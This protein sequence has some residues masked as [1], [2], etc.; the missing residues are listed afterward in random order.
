[1]TASQIMVAGF[2]IAILI[3]GIVLCLPVCN[4]DG[5]WLNFLD[6]LFTACS[7]VCVTG[8]VTVVPA[9]QFSLVG[10]IVLLLLIQL[11]GLGIIACTMG[12]FLILRRQITVR[13]RVML[14]E[15]Y[16]MNTMSGLV[17][18]LIYVLKGTFFVEGVGALLYAIQFVPQFGLVRGVWY[19]I[20]HAVSAFCNA[21]IDLLGENSLQMYQTNPLINFTTIGL[22]ILSGLGFVVWR[23]LLLAAHRIR[24]KECSAGRA[25]QRMKVHTKLAVI[26][27][28]GL[29]VIGTVGIFAMEYSNPDTLGPLSTG[30]KWM[31]ALFQ[32]VTTRTAGFF[33][34]PQ[35]SLREESKL[36]SCILMFIG[37]SPGGTAGGVKTTTVAL[38]L[39]TCWSVLKGHED[40]ECYRRR[41]PP[42]NVRT[43]FSVFT[44]AFVAVLAG[45]LLVLFMEPFAL[46]DVLY[47]VVS[48]VG[49]VGLST[50]ITSSLC[51]GSKL[52]IIF[53][54]YMGRIGPVT[55]ALLFAARA[56]KKG[57]GRRLPEERIMVG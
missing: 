51:S 41:F 53:L 50:G 4:A 35:G 12:A 13:N 57:R 1:M 33:T 48:A 15:S 42:A 31:A 44:V 39:L 2:A 54:M 29:I 55:L 38:L 23:D 43:G 37:G 34:V 8:L 22:I 24:K 3:G 9:V 56:A 18:L 49:T 28:L 47:E 11:G 20:F 46:S 40:T 32:S 30:Q 14:Q 26:M 5:R 27:T 45:S 6:A 52:V 10:K 25:V 19:S 7:A 17:V 36:L 16:N 21:G